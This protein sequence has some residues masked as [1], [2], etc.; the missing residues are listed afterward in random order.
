MLKKPIDWDEIEQIIEENQSLINRVWQDEEEC[1]TILSEVFMGFYEDGSD[2]IPL[3]E[4]F[5]RHGFDPSANEGETGA[6]CLRSLCWS[7]YDPYI[8]D[9]AKLLLDHGAK[10][11]DAVMDSIGWKLGEWT[12]GSYETGNLFSTYYAIALRARAGMDYA[13]IRDWGAAGRKRLT[14]VRLANAI[15]PEE[16]RKEKH[17][18]LSFEDL[19]LVINGY[20]ES[21]INPYVWETAEEI[22]DISEELKPILGRKLKSI[23]YSES[24]AVCLDFFNHYR[25]TVCVYEGVLTYELTDQ[26]KNALPAVGERILACRYREGFQYAEDVREYSQTGVLLVTED[27]S[28]H[29]YP[30]YYSLFPDSQTLCCDRHSRDW[31]KGIYTETVGVTGC[32]VHDIVRNDRNEPIAFCIRCEEGYLYAAVGGGNELELFLSTIEMEPAE[33]PKSHSFNKNLLQLDYPIWE[34]DS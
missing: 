10:A 5:L 30:T 6:S 28:Y 17:M 25:L 22:S 18:I 14:G 8:L 34:R 1:D 9:V 26:K 20:C 13:G 7:S 11:T 21:F 4:L 2:L 27:C 16:N 24:S 33:I 31:S 3:T 32:R 23:S 19:T 29:I 15:N 12:V